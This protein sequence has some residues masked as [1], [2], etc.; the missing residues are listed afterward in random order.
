MIPT[1]YPPQKT[2]WQLD[3]EREERDFR[4]TKRLILLALLAVA[5]LVHSCAQ[6]SDFV[7][8]LCR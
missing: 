4:L 5:V 7:A 1:Q 2:A 8:A 6:S 3:R